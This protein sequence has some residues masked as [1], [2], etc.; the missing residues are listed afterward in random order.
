[1]IQ[2]QSQAQALP[3]LRA[4]PQAH[5]QTH[6]RRQPL[7]QPPPHS[8]PRPQF[9]SQNQDG[10]GFQEAPEALLPRPQTPIRPMQTGLAPNARYYGQAQLGV[11]QMRH[12]SQF[13]RNPAGM[14]SFAAQ[15]ADELLM[16]MSTSP[17]NLVG[18][19]EPRYGLPPPARGPVM[20]ANR[21][22]ER[23]MRPLRMRQPDPY[24]R[25]QL[26]MAEAEIARM[27]REMAQQGGGA[28]VAEMYDHDRDHGWQY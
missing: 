28:F 23:S 3:Q 21:L 12:P 5:A 10:H 16:R 9:Q 24:R 11:P 20:S 15:V 26:V 14:G 2:V 25:A 6:P 4:Q 27:R 22:M 8:R 1:M 17:L 13:P 18:A 19:L 7:R